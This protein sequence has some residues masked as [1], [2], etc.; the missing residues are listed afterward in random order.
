MRSIE[1]DVGQ[2]GS[3]ALGSEDASHRGFTLLHIAS[4]C[5]TTKTSEMPSKMVENQV[6]KT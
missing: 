5:F 3:H 1:Q 4:H 6:E 2:R